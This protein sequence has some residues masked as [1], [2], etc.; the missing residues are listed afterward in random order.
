MI[1]SSTDDDSF[2]DSVDRLMNADLR[3]NR[4]C[5]RMHSN[6]CN[7]DQ[8]PQT[9]VAVVEICYADRCVADEECYPAVDDARH[10]DQYFVAV[11]L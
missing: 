7:L 9:I 6:D 11:N 1:H 3:K 2:V 8:R 10:D 5:Y 4:F